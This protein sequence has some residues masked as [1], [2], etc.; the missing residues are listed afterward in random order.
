MWRATGAA[1]ALPPRRSPAPGRRPPWVPRRGEGDEQGVVAVL[2]LG[3]GRVVDLVL[4]R[5]TTWAVPDLPAA[6]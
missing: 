4:L 6:L 3:G 2:H 1:M 5:P